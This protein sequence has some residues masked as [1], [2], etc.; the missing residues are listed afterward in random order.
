M[1]LDPRLDR[2]AQEPILVVDLAQLVEGDA[3]AVPQQGFLKLLDFLL[4]FADFV[5]VLLADGSFEI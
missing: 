5:F 4:F 3:H 2:L 1:R